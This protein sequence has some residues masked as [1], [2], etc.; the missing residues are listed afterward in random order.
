MHRFAPALRR[1]ARELDLPR[2]A[3]ATVL[4][5]LAGDLDAVYAHHRERGLGEAEAQRR[6][7]ETVLGTTQ[8]IRRLA[9]LH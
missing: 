2:G 1:V 5:E 6:A 4:R 8:V 7:E 9:R 3:R